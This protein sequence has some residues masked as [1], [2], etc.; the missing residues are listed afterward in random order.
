MTKTVRVKVVIAIQ[1]NGVWQ[2]IGEPHCDHDWHIR[3]LSDGAK[4][5]TRFHYATITLPVPG[6]PNI[7]NSG[8]LEID[9]DAA[10]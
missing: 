1:P 4:P 6:T 9:A 7:K 8:I 3:A 2:A 5:G 10:D